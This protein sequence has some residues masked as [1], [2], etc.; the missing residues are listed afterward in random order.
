MKLYD[1]IIASST[2]NLGTSSLIDAILKNQ[3]K[4]VSLVES[5]TISG[6]NSLGSDDD[7]VLDPDLEMI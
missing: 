7:L 4:H 3:F 1:F 2:Y 5:G 6:E